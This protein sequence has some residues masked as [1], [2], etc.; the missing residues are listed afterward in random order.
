[1]FLQ[2]VSETPGN[3]QIDNHHGYNN[4]CTWLHGISIL[5]HACSSTYGN[6]ETNKL[7][8]IFQV[9]ENASTIMKLRLGVLSTAA[10]LVNVL[11]CQAGQKIS[12]QVQ[13]IDLHSNPS[14]SYYFQMEGIFD[15][16]TQC[17]WYNW[18][19]KNKQV[20]LIFME[21][22]LKPCSLGF[23]GYVADYQ[24]AISV[25]CANKFARD[26]LNIVADNAH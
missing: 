23:A 26:N 25:S 19:A 9:Y 17:S 5:R 8:T 21:N 13:L 11:Y 12:D 16:L 24:Q 3:C 6:P 14:F 20:L 4:G 2:G 18:D 22:S 10:I 7:I 1:L 15:T